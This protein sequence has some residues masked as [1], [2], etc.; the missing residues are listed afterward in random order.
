MW[1]GDRSLL[2]AAGVIRLV[3]TVLVLVGVNMPGGRER[4][5]SCID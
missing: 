2:R 4:L 3:S 1:F 5:R